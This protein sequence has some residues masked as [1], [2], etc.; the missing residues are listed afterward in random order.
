MAFSVYQAVRGSFES[1]VIS[2]ASR[3]IAN[4]QRVALVANAA[5]RILL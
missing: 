5:N 4:I 3:A 2:L 1:G